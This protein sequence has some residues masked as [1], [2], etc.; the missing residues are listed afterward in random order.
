MP[1]K[2]KFTKDEIVDAAFEIVRKEGF[3]ALTARA[4]G[5]ALGS[6]PRPIFTVFKSMEEVQSEVILR[7][8]H[9]YESYEDRGMSGENAFKGSGTGYIRFASDE[10]KLFQL[11]FMKESQDVPSS[12]KVLQSI[13]GYYEKI[14][15][16]V[17]TEYAFDRETA[18]RLYLHMWLYSHGIAVA[19]ATKI[20]TFTEEQISG[21]LTD[22]CSGLIQKIKREQM[23]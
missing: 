1:P 2:A 22:V 6:S 23:K 7:A 8:R 11:F 13:D 17:E 9:L 5:A 4:L 16:A 12:D 15:S 20:C 10:P 14:L 19:I 21:M 18:E 3:E